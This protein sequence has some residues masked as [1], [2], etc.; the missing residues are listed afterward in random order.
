MPGLL[1]DVPAVEPCGSVSPCQAI[2]AATIREH[3]LLFQDG[4]NLWSRTWSR[5]ARESAPRDPPVPW[6]YDAGVDRPWAPSLPPSQ[7]GYPGH[8]LPDCRVCDDSY[9]RGE[10]GIGYRTAPFARRLAGWGGSVWLG[11]ADYPRDGADLN[12]ALFPLDF[13][14][15]THPVPT[16]RLLARPNEE[17]V[18]RIAHPAGRARQRAFLMMGH[19][20][21][22]LLPGF[23]SGHSGLIGPGKA[24]TAS[25]CAASDAGEYLYRDGPQHIFAGGVWGHLA[26]GSAAPGSASPCR[27]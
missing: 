21:E 1:I 23:G 26:V 20:Y 13:F 19:S 5:A 27:P 15:S 9:D 24:L 12:A 17:V 4:L 10:R 3:T 11:I 8:P 25:T 2:P 7:R 6:G 14:A 22:D 18:I 16:P